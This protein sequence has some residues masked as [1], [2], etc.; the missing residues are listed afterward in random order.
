MRGSVFKRC[1]CP[2]RVDDKGRKITC[3]KPHGSWSYKVDVP[4]LDGTRRQL[5]R[6]GFGTRKEAEQALP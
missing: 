5:L 4:A 1:T 2:V 6:G 3:G